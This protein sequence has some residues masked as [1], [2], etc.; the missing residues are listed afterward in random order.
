MEEEKLNDELQLVVFKLAEE[1]YGFAINQVEEI[2]KMAEATRVPKAPKYISGI[3]NLRGKVIPVIN[4]KERF[5]LAQSALD[6]QNRIIVVEIQDY[7][8]GIMVDCVT[9]VLRLSDTAVE[10]T[11]SVFSSNISDEYIKGVGKLNER[12]IILLDLEHILSIEEINEYAE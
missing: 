5:N 4:L 7:S 2:I 3:I 6:D 12:L 8:V 1:E 10:P 11:P 9:E